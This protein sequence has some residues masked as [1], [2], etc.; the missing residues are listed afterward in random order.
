MQ[1]RTFWRLGSLV[2]TASAIAALAVAT[3]LSPSPTP[4]AAQV[5]GGTVQPPTISV[6]GD[7]EV[8][9]EPDMATLSLGVT[10]V[11]PTSQAAMDEVNRKL[12][13]VVAGARS[14][15]IGDRDLQTSG[16]S[17]QPNYRQRPR[18]DD[19]PLEIES[20]RASN[21]VTIVVR[22][23]SQAGPVLDAATAAGANSVGGIRFGVSNF[24]ELRLQALTQ[25]TANASTK[26][27]AI[28][29]GAGVTITGVASLSEESSSVPSR[30]FAAADSAGARVAAEAAPTVV[31]TGELTIRARVH[32]SYYI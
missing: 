12:A 23:L 15:G 17:L 11:A 5:S 22:T 1:I 4:V 24:E 30:P 14:L 2:S 20:Y 8:R 6:N 13:A 27:Q 32:A 19:T 3:S 7:G 18:N 9:A 31:E 10:A 28:A 25:A 29:S 26:A 16:L 21:N